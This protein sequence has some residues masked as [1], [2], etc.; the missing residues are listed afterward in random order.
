MITIRP[1]SVT[2][3]ADTSAEDAP[4]TEEQ[5]KRLPLLWIPATL[6]VGLLIA[7]VYLGG[8]IATPR[9]PAKPEMVQPAAKPPVPLEPPPAQAQ[10]T[11]PEAASPPTQKLEAAEPLTVVAPGDDIP[12][13]APQPGERYIQ[14]GAL[15]QEATRRFVQRLRRENLDPHVAPG[16]KPELMRVLIGPFDHRDALSARK[17]QLESEGI[18]TFVREY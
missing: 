16:P 15:D 6:G 2:D 13:I 11:V 10:A 5:K 4:N 17:T 1:A 14:V 12:L 8:R 18:A 3:N 7:A 9:P